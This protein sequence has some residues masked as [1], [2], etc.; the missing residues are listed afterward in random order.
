MLDVALEPGEAL[1]WNS[2]RALVQGIPNF[3]TL[4]SMIQRMRLLRGPCYIYSLLRGRD[5][6]GEQCGSEGWGQIWRCPMCF[7]L[8]KN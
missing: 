8:A 5:V 1:T 4:S 6:V 2:P 3:W 7:D